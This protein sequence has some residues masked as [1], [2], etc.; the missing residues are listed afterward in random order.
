MEQVQSPCSFTPDEKGADGSGLFQ[1]NELSKKVS[2][3]AG[4]VRQFSGA[5]GTATVSSNWNLS[6]SASADEIKAAFRRP[7]RELHPD[8]SGLE[9][10][11]F[12]EVQEAYGVL[13]DPERRREYDAEAVRRVRRQ[14][15]AAAAAEPLVPLRPAPEPF[16][17]VTSASGFHEL[18][19]APEFA[20]YQ[21]SFDEIFDRLWSNFESLTRPKSEG[22]ESLTLEVVIGPQDARS[23]RHVRGRCGTA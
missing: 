10:S 6:A 16:G 19:L 20:E 5:G 4:R 18:G 15:W 8:T 17:A 1:R 23:G 2:E 14:P 11:P 22:V 7:G 21:P 13:S 12:L 9:S 3:V